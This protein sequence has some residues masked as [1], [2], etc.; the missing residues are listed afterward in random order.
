MKC[1]LNPD[2]KMAAMLFTRRDAAIPIIASAI[3]IWAVYTFPITEQRAYEVRQ[4]LERRRGK[5]EDAAPA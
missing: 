4:E 3:A 1:M 5:A 2:Q